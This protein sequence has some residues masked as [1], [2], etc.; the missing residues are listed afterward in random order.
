MIHPSM[1]LASNAHAFAPQ[2]Q[3]ILTAD[4]VIARLFAAPKPLVC[5]STVSSGGVMVI[6]FQPP[7]GGGLQRFGYMAAMDRVEQRRRSAAPTLASCMR[8]RTPEGE[9]MSDTTVL[10]V[11][12]HEMHAFPAS[13]VVQW[14][15]DY[16]IVRCGYSFGV[17]RESD[18]TE[19]PMF[20]EAQARGARFI[21]SFGRYTGSVA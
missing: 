16:G 17:A 18:G 13:V 21:L 14:E 11:T 6:H 3:V 15:Q 5:G 1:R 20:G 8:D 12:R 9:T 4:A 10:C 19:H 7:T 2:R